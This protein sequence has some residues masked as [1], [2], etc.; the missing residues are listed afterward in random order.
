[1]ENVNS[2]SADA[3]IYWS[4]NPTGY[5]ANDHSPVLSRDTFALK[6]NDYYLTE[7]LNIKSIGTGGPHD[8]P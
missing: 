7:R 2:P 5:W 1:L 6:N 3:E 8:C 4:N